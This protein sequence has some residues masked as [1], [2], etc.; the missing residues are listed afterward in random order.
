MKRILLGLLGFALVVIGIA[1]VLK[2]WSAVVM[3]FNGVIGGL[4]AI[5]GLVVLCTIKD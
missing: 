3:V 1:L 4:L 2:H 5:A